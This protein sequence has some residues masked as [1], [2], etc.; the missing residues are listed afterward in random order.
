MTPPAS[1]EPECPWRK[2]GVE[3]K[4][5]G[6]SQFNKREIGIIWFVFGAFIGGCAGLMF[7][8]LL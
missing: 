2:E 4:Y 5:C 3:K 1:T 8:S 7:G 6:M